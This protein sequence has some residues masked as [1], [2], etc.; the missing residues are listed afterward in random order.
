MIARPKPCKIKEGNNY[1]GLLLHSDVR[2]LSKRMVFSRFPA[3]QSKI[4]TF[5]EMKNV[6][7][8][9]LTNIE[10]FRKFYFLVYLTEHINQPNV[11]MQGIGNT[12]LYLQQ[13][14][15]AF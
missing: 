3:C 12:I 10:W 13:A 6:E 15:F 2:W 1:N 14:V 5:L 7:H 9:E 8:P 11:K 4:W